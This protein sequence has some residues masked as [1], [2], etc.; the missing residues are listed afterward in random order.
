MPDL[1]PEAIKQREDLRISQ[2]REV[3]IE[4][5]L[6]RKNLVYHKV[7]MPAF[8]DL[9]G[10]AQACRS[11]M[12]SVDDLRQLVDDLGQNLYVLSCQFIKNNTVMLRYAEGLSESK[13]LSDIE[14]ASEPLDSNFKLRQKLTA[15]IDREKVQ[16]TVAAWGRDTAAKLIGELI[17][18]NSFGDELRSRK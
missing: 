17:L 5:V 18:S 15:M 8:L 16:D 6:D 3:T 4:E 7:D 1:S 11:R 9:S 2:L 12:I 13:M 14:V 10:E